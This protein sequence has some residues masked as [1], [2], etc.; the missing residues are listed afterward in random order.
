MHG[1]ES[2]WYRRVAAGTAAVLGRELP[3]PVRDDVS[4]PFWTVLAA[5]RGSA[6]AWLGEYPVLTVSGEQ[7][8]LDRSIARLDDELGATLGRFLTVLALIVIP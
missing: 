7:G 1:A 8:S 3:I 2:A 5:L 6:V 4:R